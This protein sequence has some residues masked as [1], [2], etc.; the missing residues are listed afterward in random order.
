MANSD[1]HPAVVGGDGATPPPSATRPERI[2]LAAAAAASFVASLVLA[3]NIFS[4]FSGNLDEGVYVF[5]AEM[6][7][8]EMVTLPAD[9]H[10]EFFRPWLTGIADGQI[11]TQ[12]QPGLPAF[13]AV[14]GALGSWRVGL[15]LLAPALTYAT[16]LLTRELF[17]RT[18]LA[19][20][21]AVL[22]SASP[23]F[24]LHSALAL[25]YLLTSV[26][27]VLASGLWLLAVRREKP[28]LAVATGLLAGMAIVTRP[29]D[30]ALFIAPFAL[31][32]LQR[33]RACD[34]GGRPITALVAAATA[35]AVAAVAILLAY[36]AATTGDPFAFPN[37]AADPLNGF[38]F[39][40][41]R[42]LPGEPTIDYFAGDA[43]QALW[44]NVRSVPSWIIGGPVALGFAV[45]GVAAG[46]RRQRAEV[47]ALTV[48]TVS[49]P[50]A[51]LFWWATVL[52]ADEATN[53][54]GPHY[55]V[56]AFVPLLILAASGVARVRWTTRT[57]G[58]AAAAVVLATAWSVPDKFAEQRSVADDF[59]RVD[60]LVP[61]DLH[62]AI[63]LLDT[64]D[65]PYILG[66]WPFL[67]P[68]PELT[69]EVLYAAEHSP[70]SPLLADTFG[71][72]SLYRL[73]SEARP[74]DVDPFSPTG[75]FTAL[76]ATRGEA[77]AFDVTIDTT[78]AIVGP[79]TMGDVY[80]RLDGDR[81]VLRRSGNTITF[82]VTT[83]GGD[84]DIV[85]REAATVVVGVELTTP[86]GEVEVAQQHIP[87]AVADDGHLVTL[88]P[89]RGFV[90]LAFPGQR[91]VFAAD[92]SSLVVVEVAPR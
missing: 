38:G 50:L 40:I 44:S 66:R 5:Q 13:L 88:L 39:G 3:L 85:L 77:L 60:A 81:E 52:S 78:S 23:I 20:G 36:N 80:V 45:Y 57:A 72:R 53:A 55:Y 42:L 46:L 69:G 67:A 90:E 11:F 47:V 8:A 1:A 12:Y 83:A 15:A 49:F 41:R 51:Y 82:E 22:V 84:G 63:V 75:G 71:D 17:G 27:V 28:A 14:T 68:D 48:A 74:G 43:L 56:P 37:M 86:T 61:D 9:T 92:V 89:G 73:R 34:L 16:Y 2:A 59:A 19:V 33:A 31:L 26:T 64:A 35:P 65:K 30:A 70:R 91:A 58:L 62:D 18:R 21:A 25:T 32:G 87:I 76:T 24:L 7:R 4:R 10:G 79:R 6:F 29:L 54:I